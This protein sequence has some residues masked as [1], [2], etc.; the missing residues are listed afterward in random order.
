MNAG[1]GRWIS[2]DLAAQYGWDNAEI[3]AM[4]RPSR[5]RL[6]HWWLRRLLWGLRAHNGRRGWVML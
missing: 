1:P 2:L 6:V 5:D 3:K 4:N